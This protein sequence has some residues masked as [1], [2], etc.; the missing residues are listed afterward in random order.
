VAAAAARTQI[1]MAD[2]NVR[3]KAYHQVARDAEVRKKLGP[4]VT[5][6]VVA[7]NSAFKEINAALRNISESKKEEGTP[8]AGKSQDVG[9]MTVQVLKVLSQQ[10]GGL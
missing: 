4:G 6:A 10:P 3:N 5:D 8:G 7:E 9:Q 1:S 2:A